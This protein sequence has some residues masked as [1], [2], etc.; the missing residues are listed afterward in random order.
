MPKKEHSND[1]AEAIVEKIKEQLGL[2]LLRNWPDIERIKDKDGGEI[3][4][5]AKITLVER[6]ATPGEQADK[7]NRIKTTIAFAEKHSDSAESEIPNPD[8]AELGMG[9]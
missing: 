5:G 4:I 6:K 9:Q 7:D 2:I 8:Q 3:T 1:K